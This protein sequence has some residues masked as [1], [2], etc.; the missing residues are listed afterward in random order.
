MR[1]VPV[2]LVAAFISTVREVLGSGATGLS[3]ATPQQRAFGSFPS[4][5]QRLQRSAIRTQAGA[6]SSPWRS[7]PAQSFWHDSIQAPKQA[8]AFPTP[9]Q[10]QD[11]NRARRSVVVYA[12][13]DFY[14]ILGV[15]RGAD[16]R[17]IK[18]AYRK[19]ARQYHPDVAT[20]PD[21][22]EKFKEIGAAYEVLSDPD[23]R[24]RYDQFGEAGL[25]G[26]AGFGGPG[27]MGG[28]PFDIFEAFFGGGM[29]G[30]SPFGGGFGGAGGQRQRVSRGADLQM[31]VDID[32]KQAVFGA[33]K[34]FDFESKQSCKTCS[35]SGVK[36]GSSL[37]TCRVCGGQ[38]VTLRQ[39][40][41]PIGVMQTQMQC[42]SCNGQ[43]Q[44]NEDYC[45]QCNGQG[46]KSERKPL[47]V[48]IPCGIA[49]GMKLR[50][51]GKGDAGEKGAP[52]GDLYLILKVRKDPKFTR[53]DRTILSSKDIQFT[54]AI[55]GCTVSVDTVDGPQVD[56]KI[57][58][59]TQPGDRL[60]LRGKGVP[61]VSKPDQRGDHIVT[62]K[63]NIPKKISEDQKRIIEQFK[64][65]EAKSGAFPF[66]SLDAQFTSSAFGP[67][68]GLCALAFFMLAVIS[69]KKFHSH[70]NS[71]PALQD[72]LM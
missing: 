21:A 6:F 70:Q 8:G 35:G 54:D 38:G 31:E 32:F 52:P 37:K 13:R 53:D 36:P 40:Q 19:L 58:A 26:D 66:A 45:R 69:L 10:S 24:A 11:Q 22:E 67:P 28:D 62:V 47:S 34:E 1:L 65:T 9:T 55:L 57:P 33:T 49:D 51:A 39:I 29:G 18:S 72:P 14:S 17:A 61:V 48:Q 64:E 50:L 63:V 68:L 15:P 56:M 4:L 27:G 43:G 23:K 12:D 20:A 46:R 71:A 2:V 16:E 7:S 41:T 60:R 42:Q 30:G 5:G 3:R 44:I 25:G 59:G